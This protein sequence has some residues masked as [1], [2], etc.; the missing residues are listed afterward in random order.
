MSEGNVRHFPKGA[1][2]A[3]AALIVF[4]ISVAVTARLTG[5]GTTSMPQGETLAVRELRFLDGPG[6]S[7]LVIDANSGGRVATFEPGGEDGFARVVLRSLARERIRMNVG[8][9]PP[10]LLTQ[11]TDKR[12]TLE[13][14]VTGQRVHLGAFGPANAAVFERLMREQRSELQ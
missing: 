1:L 13:D 6:G 11:R 4:S 2:I 5:I 9:E 12:M 3:A 8:A 10:F 7:V 14:P